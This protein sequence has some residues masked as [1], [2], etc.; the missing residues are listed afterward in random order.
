VPNGD[1][2]SLAKFIRHLATDTQLAEQMGIAGRRYLESNF[3][4]EI[5]AAQYS[6]LLNQAVIKAQR[7]PDSTQ[8]ETFPLSF[9]SNLPETPNKDL[10]H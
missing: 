6:K 4:P 5:I 9:V 8:L 1:G 7:Q 2:T 3:T 10:K